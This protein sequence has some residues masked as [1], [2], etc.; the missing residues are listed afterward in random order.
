VG[1]EGMAQKREE[2]KVR[3]R[4]G[5][6]GTYV[7]KLNHHFSNSWM[8]PGCILTTVIATAEIVDLLFA[9]E[10]TSIGDIG[11]MCS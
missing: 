2:G 1:R 9:A 10:I 6:I 3:R 4:N 7:E 5:G 8:W 11:C